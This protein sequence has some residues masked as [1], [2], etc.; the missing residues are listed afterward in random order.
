MN[1][2]GQLIPADAGNR[3]DIDSLLLNCLLGGPGWLID[4]CLAIIGKSKNF[5]DIADTNSATDTQVLI[6][7]WCLLHNFLL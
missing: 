1:F 4:L 6:N 3:T 7:K 2:I 5:R